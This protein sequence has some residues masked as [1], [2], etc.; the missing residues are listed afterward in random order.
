MENKQN[1]IRG[2]KKCEI[3]SPKQLFPHNKN[4]FNN[5]KS[6]KYFN[7]INSEN[8][9]KKALNKYRENNF[10]KNNN[11][12]NIANKTTSTSDISKIISQKKVKNN[13]LNKNKN[14]SFKIDK[15]ILA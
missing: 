2:I 7:T 8:Q 13:V 15:K 11:I 4:T 14:K 1:K 9:I 12:N 10:K 6:S 5:L 3:K